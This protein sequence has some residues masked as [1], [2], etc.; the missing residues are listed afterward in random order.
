MSLRDCSEEDKAVIAEALKAAAEGPFFPDW[1]FSTLFGLERDEVA[2]VARDWPVV[3]GSDARVDLAVNNA[4]AN[5]CG[6]PHGCEQEWGRFLSVRPERLEE[7]LD[8][9]QRRQADNPEAEDSA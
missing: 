7:V 3:D 5:L 9:W 4:L 2:R 1:E 6:Y 8:R